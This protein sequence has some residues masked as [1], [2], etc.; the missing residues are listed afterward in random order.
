MLM[1]LFLSVPATVAVIGALVYGF[2]AHPKA[3]ELGRML[4]AVG[5]LAAL[6]ALR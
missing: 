4:F 5:A 3:A 1:K 2:A 6:L